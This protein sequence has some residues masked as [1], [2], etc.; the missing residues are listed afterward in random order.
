MLHNLFP[1]TLF[2]SQHLLSL[3]QNSSSIDKHIKGE[4]PS[5]NRELTLRKSGKP[6]YDLKERHL[7]KVPF[8]DSIRLIVI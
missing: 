6:P 3:H 2:I 5:C 1:N 8:F 4:R 7:N